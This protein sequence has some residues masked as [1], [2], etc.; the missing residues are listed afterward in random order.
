M[1][2]NSGLAIEERVVSS[3]NLH[4]IPVLDMLQEVGQPEEHD[5][6]IEVRSEALSNSTQD[7]AMDWDISNKI[8]FGWAELGVGV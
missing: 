8:A 5:F 2:N 1:K 7:E 3:N 4:P 6:A